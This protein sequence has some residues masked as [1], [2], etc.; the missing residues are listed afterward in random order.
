MDVLLYEY[1]SIMP[2][3]VD[4]FQCNDL[5]TIDTIPLGIPIS[6]GHGL[7]PGDIEAVRTIYGQPSTATV[8]SINPPGLQVLADGA[9]VTRPKTFD[10]ALSR[11]A[12]N[13]L[14]TRTP[15]R[16]APG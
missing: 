16:T 3:G 4:D 11:Y 5:N 2:Y 14:T 9:A 8:V 10:C 13:G 15:A 7:S 12:T 6:H 1:A